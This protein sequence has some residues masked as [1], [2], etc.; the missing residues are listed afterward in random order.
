M[1]FI[2]LSILFVVLVIGAYLLYQKMAKL[3]DLQVSELRNHLKEVMDQSKEMS[4]MV[5][6]GGYQEWL[7]IKEGRKPTPNDI[8]DEP[9]TIEL[10]E[11]VRIPFEDITGVSVD[12]GPKQKVKLYR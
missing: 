6:A 4:E 8:K 7:R 11:S 2:I 10:D 9:N 3:F 5:M 1:E 12:G